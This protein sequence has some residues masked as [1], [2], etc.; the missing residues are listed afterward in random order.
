MK[1]LKFNWL[2]L[3]ILSTQFAFSQTYIVKPKTLN[4]R[5]ERNTNSDVIA[6][7]YENDTIRA[8]SVEG[9]WIK[10]SISEKQGFVNKSFLEEI[11]LIKSTTKSGFKNGFSKAFSTSFIITLILLLGYRSFKGRV[12]DGRRSKGYREYDITFKD[13]IIDG[14]YA[15]II[16]LVIALIAG[17]L[18]WIKTF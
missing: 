4:V 7:I 12:K 11:N 3:L 8:I 13:Y 2:L 10:I 16:S 15:I 18:A 6:K 17:I 14:I 1:L 5:A 9:D